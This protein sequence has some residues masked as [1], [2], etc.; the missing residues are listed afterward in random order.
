MPDVL[1]AWRRACPM[2]GVLNFDSC[3]ACARKVLLLAE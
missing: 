2:A 1:R 3:R